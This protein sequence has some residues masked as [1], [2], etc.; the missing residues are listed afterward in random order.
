[1][2]E[3][4][5]ADRLKREGLVFAQG[6]RTVAGLRVHRA[7]SW[8]GRAEQAEDA[9]GRFLFL[10][11]AFNALY[12]E[13]HEP[14]GWGSEREDQHRFFGRIASCRGAS[15]VH[16]AIWTRYNEAILGLIRNRYAY[17]AFWKHRNGVPGF[18]KWQAHWERENARIQTTVMNQDTGDLLRM[19]FDRLYVVRNQLLH[20]G[21]TW[22]GRLNRT[23]AE[24]G[25]AILGSLVPIFVNIIIHHPERHWGRPHYAPGPKWR[26]ALGDTAP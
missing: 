20:G 9:D 19:L 25:A 7:V 22:G 17:Y 8:I 12:A 2:I 6:P 16:D 10:W 23:Q 5:T 14:D 26:E 4:G 13:D 3:S 24:D 18:A 11:I 1:M 15:E 21:A